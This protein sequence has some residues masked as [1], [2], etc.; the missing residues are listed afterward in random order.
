MEDETSEGWGLGGIE[1]VE[2]ITAGPKVGGAGAGVGR[3]T[4]GRLIGAGEGTLAGVSDGQKICLIVG[5]GVG[6]VVGEH[7]LFSFTPPFPPFPEYVPFPSP[8]T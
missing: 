1:G 2:V 3:V 8:D 7:L 6:F 5:L 4:G